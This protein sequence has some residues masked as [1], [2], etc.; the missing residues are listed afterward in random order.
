MIRRTKQ[1]GGS[2]RRCELAVEGVGR[3]RR[4]DEFLR[5]RWAANKQQHFGLQMGPIRKLDNA[6]RQRKQGDKPG[7][8]ATTRDWRLGAAWR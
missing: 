2:A 5:G 1:R 6:R 4:K 3:L 8:A 7:I